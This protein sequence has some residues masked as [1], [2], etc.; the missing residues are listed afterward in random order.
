LPNLTPRTFAITFNGQD[1][2]PWLHEGYVSSGIL[3]KTGLITTEGRI[4][5]KSHL[6]SIS[7]D[8]KQNSLWLPG[9]RVGFL[10]G[11]DSHPGFDNLLIEIPAPSKEGITSILSLEVC[12]GLS[13]CERKRSPSEDK[14][15]IEDPLVGLPA[16]DV[17]N[18]WLVAGGLSGIV[19]PA[20]LESLKFP[21]VKR[22]DTSYVQQAGETIFGLPGGPWW[23]WQ[24]SSGE[25]HCFRWQ[26]VLDQVPLQ[27]NEVDCKTFGFADPTQ[28]QVPQN[29]TH[30]VA[31]Q[32]GYINLSGTGSVQVEVKSFGDLVPSLYQINPN[33]A[34]ERFLN[35]LVANRVTVVG[36]ETIEEQWD[37]RAIISNNTL[38]LA[39]FLLQTYT[40]TRSTYRSDGILEKQNKKF[41]QAP[42]YPTGA[43]G[44]QILGVPVSFAI[45]PASL[46]SYSSDPS[47]VLN[48]LARGIS[49]ENPFNSFTLNTNEDS[50]YEYDSNLF[51]T[52]RSTVYQGQNFVNGYPTGL[53]PQG[54]KKESWSYSRATG[55]WSSTVAETSRGAS[56]QGLGGGTGQEATGIKSGNDAP[57]SV[58]E[59][60]KSY[61]TDEQPLK[62]VSYLTVEGSDMPMPVTP[63]REFIG[64]VYGQ[65]ELDG[66]ADWLATHRWGLF[67]GYRLSVRMTGDI[68]AR[69]REC[70]VILC[71]LT[72]ANGLR[73]TLVLEAPIYYLQNKT[74]YVEFVGCLLGETI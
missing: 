16:V 34:V 58:K 57:P 70:P 19:G 23:L 53:I 44:D 63:E 4:V 22:P 32:V 41:Y 49:F 61:L 27:L 15:G 50:T 7:L 31:T 26:S 3:S 48:S 40:V 54:S 47:P 8:P 72:R 73:H 65:T 36:S 52:G 33:K 17:L 46:A 18:N 55:Q 12:D 43:W 59:A 42:I 62:A 67:M 51:L 6:A 37:C 38:Q 74:E 71:E 13:Y 68:S 25:I 64:Y 24:D 9:R 10:S 66:I 20:P 2:T 30:C 28:Y 39:Y 1:F 35:T 11:G 5:L 21:K 60:P 29:E 14:S 45:D 56:Q 69:L